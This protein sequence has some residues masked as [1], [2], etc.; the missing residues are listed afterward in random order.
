MQQ[1]LQA[2]QQLLQAAPSP[3]AIAALQQDKAALQLQLQGL[4]EQRQ[5][6]QQQVQAAPSCDS[7][8][9]LEQGTAALQLQL[10][11]ECERRVKSEELLRDLQQELQQA[12]GELESE[13]KVR[14]EASERRVK[15]EELLRDLQQEL[16]QAKGELES[17]RKVRSEES[18]RRVQSEELLRDLQQELLQAKGELES[19]RKVKSEASERRVKNEELLRDLQLE[20]LQAK[21]E[22]EC[23][24]ERGGGI[25]EEKGRVATQEEGVGG[26][27][28]G[29]S[30]AGGLVCDLSARSPHTF[31]AELTLDTERLTKP[32]GGV[33]C[34]L[35]ATSQHQS[36]SSPQRP[37]KTST[38]VLLLQMEEELAQVCSKPPSSLRPH[39]L[40][41]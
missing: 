2:L 24:R 17:E 10:Q 16:L 12:K 21:R 37:P 8:V 30:K 23:E 11:R 40:V 20:L 26:D 31:A 13:R 29:E 1:Q 6:L 18:E 35:S 3:S 15:S 7:V 5:Q 36:T 41:A 28:D 22:L 39:T 32:L 38:E 33:L 14:S 25:G 9:A 19:E 27:A 4:E 34:D